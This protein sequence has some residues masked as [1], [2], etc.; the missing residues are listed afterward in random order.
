[1]VVNVRG[2][3]AET[4]AVFVDG[5][6]VFAIGERHEHLSGCDPYNRASSS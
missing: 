4:S 6:D 5:D 3:M 1:M 2:N